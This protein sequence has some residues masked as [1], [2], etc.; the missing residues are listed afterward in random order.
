ME[1]Y[2]INDT[3]YG[4]TTAA[5]DDSSL[6]ESDSN[7]VIAIIDKSCDKDLSKYYS[8]FNKLLKQ[9]NRIIMVSVTDENKSFK[10]LA[11]LL[12]TFNNY[13]IYE[14]AERDTLTVE[15]FKK[16]E[17][18]EPDYSEVQTYIGGDIVA[19]SD[20]SMIL[21]GI[22]S[23][24]E[25]GNDTALKSFLEE[26]MVSIE[27]FTTSLNSMKKTCDIFNSNELVNEVTSLK[28]KEKKLNKDLADKDSIIDTLKQNETE[29]KDE[30][31]TLRLE[32]EKLKERNRDLEDQGSS[33]ST[34]RTFK[35]VNTQLLK[36]S[37]TK[38]IIYFKEISYVRY[39]NTL[40]TILFSYIKR[41]KKDINA[42]MLIYDTNSEMN[43]VYSPLRIIDGNDY[44]LNKD[45]IVNKLEKAVIAEPSQNIIEDILTQPKPLD[46]LIIY[47]RM[48]TLNDVVDGNLVTKFY[49]LNSSK[50]FESMKPQLKINDVS[51]VITS[52]DN[53]LNI[54]KD[55]KIVGDRD[56]IDIPTIPDFKKNE[57]GSTAFV[58]TKYVKQATANTQKSIINTIIEKSKVNTLF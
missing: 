53:S 34:I 20:M 23:L 4:Y 22:E 52:A 35:T 11:S 43:S 24:L 3:F 21:F 51:T 10:I 58:F 48:H 41:K 25:E 31:S 12:I 40:V 45:M 18:R 57:M 16:L 47:D 33:G 50:D 19:F 14:V 38:I 32:N 44:V 46:V 27:N 15:Y 55:W 37:N 29:S 42:K 30:L 26:H 1:K 17:A 6:S 5:I 54:S 36:G 8:S 9:H 28:D 7:L 13:D 39:M 2:I 49:V 56:F